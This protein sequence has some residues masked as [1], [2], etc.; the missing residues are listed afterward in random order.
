MNRAVILDRDGVINVDTGFLYRIEECRFI[1]GIFDLARYFT[2]SGFRLV[3]ATNQSGIG[4]GYFTEADFRRLMG[5]MIER[6]REHGVEIDR[7]YHAPDRPD[8]PNPL[9]PGWRKPAP[10]MLLQAIADLGLDRREC[11]AIGD[12]ARDLVAADAAG[13]VH[14]V[15]LDPAAPAVKRRG[16]HWVVP[17]LAEIPPLLQRTAAAV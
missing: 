17:R 12:Q 15:L 13:I 1:D 16:G 5:W 3:I 14:R 2:D 11:W 9:R 8:D 7:I 4:R 6:F 10:G